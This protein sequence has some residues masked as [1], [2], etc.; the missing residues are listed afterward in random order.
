VARL[1][2]EA[3]YRFVFGHEVFLRT[4]AISLLLHVTIEVKA[5]LT[6]RG[7][8]SKCAHTRPLR[9]RTKGREPPRPR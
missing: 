7:R 8:L 4:F 5:R 3:E 6:M 2:Y 1:L 9:L